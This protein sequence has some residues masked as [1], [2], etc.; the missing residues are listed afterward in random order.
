M[1][2]IVKIDFYKVVMPEAAATTFDA[3]LNRIEQIP[4]QNEA[5]TREIS[6]DP[7]H[8]QELHQHGSH[9]RRR[10]GQDE[11]GHAAEEVEC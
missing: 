5:R 11:D 2:K 3:L 1:P 7:V 4:L 9:L 6:G 10:Y 8:L